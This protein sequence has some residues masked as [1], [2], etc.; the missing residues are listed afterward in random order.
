[1]N[2]E[3]LGLRGEGGEGLGFQGF[4]LL[5]GPEGLK[6]VGIRHFW[7][8]FDVYTQQGGMIRAFEV[9]PIICSHSHFMQCLDGEY[10]RESNM[11][12]HNQ[13]VLFFM[14][15]S[16]SLCSSLGFTESQARF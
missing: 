15:L 13:R 2:G 14:R 12:A 1:M 5:G 3:G 16:S 9:D 10:N 11:K 7:G 8:F 6:G 4:C